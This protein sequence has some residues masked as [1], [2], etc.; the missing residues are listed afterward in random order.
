MNRFLFSTGIENSY[1]TIRLLD[2]ETARVDEMGKCGHYQRWREDF[3]LVRDLGIEYLR[4]GPPYYRTHLG[5]G[6]YDWLFADETFNELHKLNINPIVDLCHFGVP[7]WAGNF[8]NP[9]WPALFAEYAHAFAARFPWVRFY[10]PVNEIYVCATFSAQWGLWNERLSSDRAFVTALQNLCRATLLAERAILEIRPD[11]RF[12][13]SESSE[14]FHPEDPAVR[15]KADLFNEKRF[16][17]LDLCYGKDVSA[18]MYQY[19]T[20][21][22]M[23]REDYAWFQHEGR[24]LKPHCI[25]GN[26]YYIT[27]ERLVSKDGHLSRAGEIFG[28][29][30]IARQYFD[31][32]HMPVMHTETNLP[33]SLKSPAWLWKEWANIIRLKQDGVPI[34]GF[35]WYSLTDQVDWDTGLCENNGHVNPLGL[36]DLDRKIRPVGEQYRRLIAQ[37]G[38]ALPAESICL[39]AD[40]PIPD[41]F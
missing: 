4:Y 31:R 12:I 41:M 14:Y 19:L 39:H 11:A 24:A 27:N 20:D 21:N 33:D 2:G 25:M 34:I 23:S 5:P 22:E 6:S 37:W 7:D 26:D 40:R 17:S 3:Q 28:F 9:E 29:Y 36:Y 1:P 35:T 13:Q 38:E 8:Q 15:E 10:T 30:V 16:L 32:Y 18:R